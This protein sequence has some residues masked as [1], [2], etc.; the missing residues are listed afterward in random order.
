LHVSFPNIL[1]FEGVVMKTMIFFMLFSFSFLLVIYS[2]AQ[3]YSFYDKGMAA[4]DRG[5]TASAEKFFQESVKQ[6][7]DAP[8]YFELAKI[9]NNE[10]SLFSLD[11]ARGNLIEAV[12]IDPEN[13]EYRFFLG[14]VFERIDKR[15]NIEKF[16]KLDFYSRDK[17]INTYEELLKINPQFQPAHL[18][19]AELYKEDYY[20]NVN[21]LF[22]DL[23]DYR[24]NANKLVHEEKDYSAYN[25]FVNDLI[26]SGQYPA[27]NLN[28]LAGKSLENSINHYL[29]SSMD[30]AHAF[31]DLALM[32]AHNGKPDSAI[33]IVDEGM[34][35]FQGNM[36][37]ILSAAYLNYKLGNY[38]DAQNYFDSSFGLMDPGEVKDYKVNSVFSLLTPDVKENVERLN[39]NETEKFIKKY[40]QEHDPLI[41][42]QY[43]ERELEHYSRVFYANCYFGIPGKNIK[44]WR[45]DRGEIYLRYGDPQKIMRVR[46]WMDLTVDGTILYPETEIINYPDG[47]IFAFVD[48][49]QNKEFLLSEK[50]ISKR[51]GSQFLTDSKGLSESLRRS[52][53]EQF[54]LKWKGSVLNIP[55][56]QFQF[57]N[58]SNKDFTDFYI[59]YALNDSTDNVYVRDLAFMDK[60]FNF[61]FHKQDTIDYSNFSFPFASGKI[62]YIF[63]SDGMTVKPDSGILSF[64]VLR[65]K[66]NG[67]YINRGSYT[68]KDYSGNKLAISDI[69][70]AD[71]VMTDGPAFASIERNGLNILPNPLRTFSKSKFPYIYFEIYNLHKNEEQLTDFE[72]SISVG[73][74]EERNFISSA[75]V[76]LLNFFGISAG[77]LKINVKS[78]YNTVETDP[79]IYIQLDL[80]NYEP[81]EYDVLVKIKDNITGDEVTTGT[82]IIWK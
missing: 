75:W 78:D 73:K 8:S 58:I 70:L 45:S 24:W 48:E 18:R 46:R 31:I 21:S 13:I 36:D 28:D 55:S 26:V 25:K 49:F 16:F 71:D 41:I 30:S 74:E 4:L 22:Y 23:P 40:W 63:D 67:I 20:K 11:K 33:L 37:L 64:E 69:I 60:E 2:Q 52:E 42:T 77:G 59:S 35:K 66:D 5:D 47:R 43:N 57:K 29:K 79:Q 32:Y 3:T 62:N 51:M 50:V 38:A 6:N 27:T 80:S 44:G 81:G 56:T 39:E 19:L 14:Q 54:F 12:K 61:L 10:N 34:F 7:K 65:L 76:S 17:A 82:K 72:Q 9:L 1:I 15:S 68:V 53:P